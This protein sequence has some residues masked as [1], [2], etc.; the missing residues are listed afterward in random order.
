[1]ST[2]QNDIFFLLPIVLFI[3][4]DCFGVDVLMRFGDIGHR[5][6]SN[7]I[8]LDGTLLCSINKLKKKEIA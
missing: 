7:I 6:V 8:E 5:D 4:L 1:M 2:N 3:H